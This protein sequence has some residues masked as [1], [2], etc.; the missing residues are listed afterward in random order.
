MK[1]GIESIQEKK[2]PVFVLLTLITLIVCSLIPPSF[3]EEGYSQGWMGIPDWVLNRMDTSY[4]PD[5]FIP[6]NL[7][8][9]EEEVVPTVS[10]YVAT[11]NNHLAGG[12][13]NEAKQSFEGAIGLNINSF[14]A[15][16]GRGHALEGL[17]RYQSA[18]E[19]FDKAI[20]LCRNKDLAWAAYAG[21]GRVLLELY[22]YE[23]SVKAYK[24][25]ITEFLSVD[26]GSRDDLINLYLGL[27]KAEEKVGNIAEASYA[28]NQAELLEEQNNITPIMGTF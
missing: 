3:A 10:S 17:K 20:R 12:A 21:K 2:S 13:Y 19:S 7:T 23:E 1:A 4:L 14:D 8:D 11:G 28:L 16:L 18:E 25:A 26:K 22:Q 9:E 6:R 24:K 27:A 5:F 15:W